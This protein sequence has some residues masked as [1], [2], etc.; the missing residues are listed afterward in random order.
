[1]TSEN[2]KEDM[3]QQQLANFWKSHNVCEYRKCRK[4]DFIFWNHI[5]GDFKILGEIEGN[6]DH[7]ALVLG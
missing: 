5:C 4:Y 2:L 7:N 3:N 1:M 6:V